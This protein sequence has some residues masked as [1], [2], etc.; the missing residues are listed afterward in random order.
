MRKKIC[1]NCGRE[2]F[3]WKSK[4]ALC[5]TC[6]ILVKNNEAK[7]NDLSDSNYSLDSLYQKKE[8]VAQRGSKCPQKGNKRKSITP[9]SKKM[10]EKLS[11]YRKLRDEY[12]IAH[13]YCECCGS[14]STDLHHKKPRRYYLNDVS[15]FMA[16]CRGCHDKIHRED[17]WA[18]E[19]GYLLSGLSK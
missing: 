12:M 7:L 2:T 9:I 19:K 14:A 10:Q 6:A 11:I 16:V 5:K 4:P 15:V 13:P 8:K 3:L 18:R 1:S 17:A